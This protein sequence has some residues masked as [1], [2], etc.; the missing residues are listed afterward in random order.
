MIATRD[1]LPLIVLEDRR[2]IAFDY[3]WFT[4]ALNVAAQRAGYPN[5]W[6]APHIA[7]SVQTW[8]ET[9]ASRNTLPARLFIRAVRE[10]LK[11]IG[12]EKI[13]ECFEASAPFARI[14][15]PELAR[16][17]GNGFELAFFDALH[18]RLDEVLHSGGSYCE[19]H[20][21]HQCV[22]L[23]RQQ[24]TWSRDCAALLDEIVDFTRAHSSR[25]CGTP[26]QPGRELFL[27]VT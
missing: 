19:L 11:V 27:H 7:G 22:K 3:G 4:R 25:L 24:R 16:D 8:L 17:A 5:W 20:G 6:L 23:L 15:L 26:G 13:G 9:L 18:R 12:Y 1:S 2:A 10:A 14:S 21:L